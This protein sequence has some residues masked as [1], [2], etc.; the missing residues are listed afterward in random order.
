VT[1]SKVAKE[2]RERQSYTRSFHWQLLSSGSYALEMRART[3]TLTLTQQQ[4]TACHCLLQVCAFERACTRT[5][6]TC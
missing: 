2:Q 6:F 1:K 4:Q 5:I 3:H